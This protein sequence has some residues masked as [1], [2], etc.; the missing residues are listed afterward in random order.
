MSSQHENTFL[1]CFTST[2]YISRYAPLISG[3]SIITL[4]SSFDDKFLSFQFNKHHELSFA[5]HRN[6]SHTLHGMILY[7]HVTTYSY[8]LGMGDI[9]IHETKESL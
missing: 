4:G 1:L 6:I 3:L 7:I 9:L 2:S 8:T 5:W